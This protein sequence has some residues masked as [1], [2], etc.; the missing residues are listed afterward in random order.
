VK[1]LLTLFLVGTLV[2]TIGCSSTTKSTG[3]GGKTNPNTPTEPKEMT[4]E[5]KAVKVDGSKLT[6]ADKDKKEQTVDVPKDAKITRDGKEAKLT[7]IK[8]DDAVKVTTKDDK[9]T[10]VAATKGGE[11]PPPPPPPKETTAE[12]KAVKVD[13]SKLTYNDSKDKKE[14]TVDVPAEAKVTRDGKDAKLADIKKDDDVT[15]KSKDNKV[16]EVTAKP[17][18]PSDK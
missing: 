10:E 1:Q 7:D 4:A 18:K 8:K 2:L 6:Y 14:Q 3:P 17:G 15:I 16:T 13:G 12:G 11:P 5:G 9:V